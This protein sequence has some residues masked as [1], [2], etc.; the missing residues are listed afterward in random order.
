MGTRAGLDRRKNL[1]P[2]EFRFRTFQPVV[3][4]YTI[5]ATRP[6]YDIIMQCNN[7]KGI[8]MVMEG[9]NAVFCSSKSHGHTEGLLRNLWTICE[10]VLRKVRQPW[11]R[12]TE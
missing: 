8:I 5:R 1:V 6:T 4:R 10:R 7:N 11:P 9:S 2:K 12:R 3:S